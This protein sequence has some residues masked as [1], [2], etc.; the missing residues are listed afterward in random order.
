MTEGRGVSTTLSYILTLSITAILVSGLIV[1]GTGF[2]S[3]QRRSV[4]HSEL[5]VLGERVTANI[6]GADS[7]AS[8]AQSPEVVVL[9][10][11][12]PQRT[13]SVGYTIRVHNRTVPSDERFHY[14][15]SLSTTDPAVTANATVRTDHPVEDATLGGGNAKVVYDADTGTLEVVPA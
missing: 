9:R 12:L 1:A 3:D 10:V 13:A 14:V 5:D 11:R 8:A 6:A 2:V 4:M 15:V 7:I